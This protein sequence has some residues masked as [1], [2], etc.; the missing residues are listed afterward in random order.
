MVGISDKFQIMRIVSVSVYCNGESSEDL[1]KF[2]SIFVKNVNFNPVNP[3]GSSQLGCRWR[4][5]VDG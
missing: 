3:S 1:Q 5:L 4:V 2:S